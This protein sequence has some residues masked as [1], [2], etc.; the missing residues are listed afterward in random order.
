LAAS[1]VIRRF[2]PIRIVSYRDV[3]DLLA[4]RGLIVSNES[5]RCWVLK[6]APKIARNLRQTRPKGHGRLYIWRAVQ[7]KARFSSSWF[8]PDSINPR[9]RGRSGSCFDVRAL[10]ERLLSPTNSDPPEPPFAKLVCQD[11]QGLR[12]PTIERRTRIS[13]FDDAN[14]KSANS[15]QRSPMRSSTVLSTRKSHE[16]PF[17]ASAVSGCSP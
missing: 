4:E 9:R 11:Q 5:I 3:E 10:F 16:Q 14:E 13:R 8:S 2:L 12:A 15:A 1:A 7:A 6:F 17:D